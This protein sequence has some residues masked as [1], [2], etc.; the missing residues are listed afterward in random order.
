MELDD[1]Y[2]NGAA[3]TSLVEER[4]K[5]DVVVAERKSNFAEVVSQEKPPSLSGFK[6]PESAALNEKT[7]VT[8]DGPV[9]TEK[10]IG[11]AFPKANSTSEAVPPAMIL[12][13]SSLKYDKSASP[14]QPNVSP[15]AY[16]FGD[17]VASPKE[18]NAASAVA[19][20]FTASSADKKM[21]Q[22]TLA[23]S[24]LGSESAGHKFGVS[25][26]PKPESSSRLV[27]I[28]CY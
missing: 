5:D 4:E 23:S 12:I 2:S 10:S 11:F 14:K 3:P 18:P 28:Y 7:D 17:K 27:Y 20:F 9:V 16:S 1:D 24:S 6:P 19:S 22:F 25:S 8:S 21:P 15:P 26:D 13:Q